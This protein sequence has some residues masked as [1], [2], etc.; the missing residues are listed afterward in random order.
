MIFIPAQRGSPDPSI[1]MPALKSGKNDFSLSAVNSIEG[2]IFCMKQ[3]WTVFLLLTLALG[4]LLPSGVEAQSGQPTAEDVIEAVN[5]LRADNDLP[6]YEANSILMIIAQ[7]Q[8][9]YMASTGVVTHFDEDGARPYQ[10]AIKAGYPVAG[11]LTFGGF[12]SENIDTGAGLTP[13][14]VV[15]QWQGDAA[16]L[17]TMLSPNFK[18]I[19]VGVTVENGITY[20]VLDA[21]ASTG[22]FLT[23]PASPPSVIFTSVPG[24]PGTQVA[25]VVT[26]TALE[27]GSV[28]HVVESDQALWSI[29]LAYGL[30]IEELKQQNRLVTDDIFIGQK[31]LIS[32]T[33]P[34]T[35]T[36]E[37]TITATFGIPTSTATKPVTPTR[38]FT[39]TALPA[40]PASG[41][42]GRMV[43]GGIILAALLAAGLGAWL[44]RRKSTVNDEEDPTL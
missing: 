13:V 14:Q 38:T 4:L 37:V 23:A 35:A 15:A 9:E 34:S 5:A 39:P 11:D 3:K 33:D 27:D 17:K 12:F 18:D 7:A 43:V 6:P 40:P 2:I 10:R 30:T 36:P 21:G 32:Q 8:A 25:P 16:D 24:T 44:G 41:Q 20:Y 31:L 19:G 28:Y 1:G 42:S 22:I 29:A 26:S